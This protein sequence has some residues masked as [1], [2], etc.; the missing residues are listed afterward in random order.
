MNPSVPRLDSRRQSSLRRLSVDSDTLVPDRQDISS[1][2]NDDTIL[3]API[4]SSNDGGDWSFVY[5][6]WQF[7]H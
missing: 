6:V 3:A 7:V 5:V 2:G 4:Y 1:D